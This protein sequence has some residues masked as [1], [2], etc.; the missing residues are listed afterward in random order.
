MKKLFLFGIIVALGL[1]SCEKPKEG[2]T[3]PEAINF[4]SAAEVNDGSCIYEH[5]EDSTKEFCIEG[6]LDTM[7]LYGTQWSYV[8]DID[9]FVS[10]EGKED[11]YW[12]EKDTGLIIMNESTLIMYDSTNDFVV[13]TKVSSTDHTITYVDDEGGESK[14]W[15]I[16]KDEKEE[17]I[18]ECE[19]ENYNSWD[20]CNSDVHW[21]LKMNKL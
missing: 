19:I 8:M 18:M 1:A 2:C 21:T 10:C 16:T 4:D 6:D 20:S 15:T 11:E 9:E 5:P 3:N 7:C 12:P 17:I 13:L 14:T